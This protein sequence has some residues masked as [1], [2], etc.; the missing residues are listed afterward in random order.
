MCITPIYY[1]KLR[2][3]PP[4][5]PG[6]AWVCND[7]RENVSYKYSQDSLIDKVRRRCF[8]NIELQTASGRDGPGNDEVADSD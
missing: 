8:E 2:S 4:D 5:Y 6:I 1:M 7:F 3:M